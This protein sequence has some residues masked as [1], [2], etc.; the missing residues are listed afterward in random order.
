MTIYTPKQYAEKLAGSGQQ[1]NRAMVATMTRAAGNI[2]R[3]WR[4]Q[5]AQKNPKHAKN[6]PGAIIMRRIIITEGNVVATVEPRWGKHGQGNFGPVLEY[7]GEHSAAQ[8]SNIVALE[9]EAP[10]LIRWLEK[11]AADSV[12]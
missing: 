10:T 9:R 7:G 2:K 8:L 1:L 5:A 4:A 3:D 12:S 6:Y 11:I